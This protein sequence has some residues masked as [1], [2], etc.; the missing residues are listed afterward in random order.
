MDDYLETKRTIFPRFY[1]ISNEELVQLLS[2]VDQPEPIQA[3]LKKLF[4]NIKSLRLISKRKSLASGIVSHEDEEVPLISP[5]SLDGNVEDWLK[6]F[7][8]RMQ[9]TIRDS[10]KNCLAA[11]RVTSNKREK[12]LRHW[13]SQSCIVASEIEWT[14][15]VT[16]ALM[17]SQAEGQNKP[18]KRV[19]QAQVGEGY[20]E[21]VHFA[22]SGENAWPI[23]E[24][25]SAN[26]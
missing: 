2:L 20:Q 23:F 24:S 19:Y 9:M 5:L 16:K 25:Q 11:L 18:L 3:Y 14:S 17:A 26:I 4:E 13:P 7:E 8:S 12:W 10:L 6:E 1:F 21:D 15:R 22:R